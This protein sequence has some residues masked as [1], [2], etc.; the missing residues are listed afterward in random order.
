MRTVVHY[1]DTVELGGAEKMLLTLMEGLC[2]SAWRQL[3]F[4]HPR[5]ALAPLVESASRAG[6]EPVPVE[7]TGT[8]LD[9]RRLAHAIRAVHADV[10][11]AHLT[12]GLRCTAGLFAALA[13]RTP[14]VATQQLLVRDRRRSARIRQR[15]VS[16]FVESVSG[17]IA[18][19]GR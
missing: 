9:P 13:T 12:W 10:F 3:L 11:H 14:C 19:H 2:P 1:T 7:R 4:F 16:A 8:P 18:R 17:R 6:V 5:P 15:M